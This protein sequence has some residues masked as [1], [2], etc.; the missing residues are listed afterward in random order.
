MSITLTFFPWLKPPPINPINQAQLPQENIK[1][2]NITTIITFFS[3]S[4]QSLLSSLCQCTK[5]SRGSHGSNS[6]EPRR[7]PSTIIHHQVITSARGMWC[8][9][10]LLDSKLAFKLYCQAKA[11]RKITRLGSSKRVLRCSPWC[12]WF[13][14]QSLAPRAT[15]WRENKHETIIYVLFTYIEFIVVNC[16]LL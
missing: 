12:K 3:V 7:I 10:L 1:S 9:K 5:S 2:F 13:A 11:H 6:H 4:I 16:V 14:R 15:Y 8:S